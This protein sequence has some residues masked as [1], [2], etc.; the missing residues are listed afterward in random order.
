MF[1]WRDSFLVSVAAAVMGKL[2]PS[3]VIATS[4]GVRLLHSYTKHLFRLTFPSSLRFN[5]NSSVLYSES[6]RLKSRLGCRLS[7][8][9][10]LWFSSVPSGKCRPFPCNPS[11]VHY[12]S[13]ILRV[14]RSVSRGMASP[15]TRVC[16]L[17]V[18]MTRS[19]GCLVR[20]IPGRFFSVSLRPQTLHYLL[21][22]R[23]LKWTYVQFCDVLVRSNLS[24]LLTVIQVPYQSS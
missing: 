20:K 21:N 24:S 17:L 1:V 10:F 13:N 15:K 9:S 3:S 12:S 5:G 7:W 8:L 19:T 2:L 23:Y 6:A 18:W 14:L 22:R 11:P 16:A 4:H